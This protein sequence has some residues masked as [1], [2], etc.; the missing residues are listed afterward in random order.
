MK[1]RQRT[2][3]IRARNRQGTRGFLVRWTV[4]HRRFRYW[5]DD[6]QEAETVRAHLQ[7][8]DLTLH[9]ALLRVAVVILLLMLPKP[10]FAQVP[11]NPWAD[12]ASTVTAAVNPTLSILDAWRSDHR[13]C[14]LGQLAISEAVANAAALTLQHFIVSA[15][16]CLGCD[17]HGMPSE[18]VAASAP[19]LLR[20]PGVGLMFTFA[21]ASLRVAAHRHTW[22]QVVAGAGIGIAADYSGRLLRCER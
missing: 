20:D 12:A 4:D 13:A 22:P 17:R 5:T 19:G 6:P 16:P 9:H 15:R 2:S 21:T 11:V 14:R 8:G 18:H 3:I 1:I 10:S 7:A